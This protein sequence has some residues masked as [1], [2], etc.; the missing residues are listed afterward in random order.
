MGS[1]ACGNSGDAGA[2]GRLGTARLVGLVRSA[3]AT[4]RSRR[5]GTAV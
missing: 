4:T 3:T 1:G 5:R 2:G